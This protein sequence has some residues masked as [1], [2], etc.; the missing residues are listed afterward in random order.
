MTDKNLMATTEV[1]LHTRPN[2]ENEL[3]Q[4]IFLNTAKAALH[5]RPNIDI[6]CNLLNIA[7]DALRIMPSIER[8]AIQLNNYVNIRARLATKLASQA[9]RYREYLFYYLLGLM[10]VETL[11]LFGIVFVTAPPHQLIEMHQTTLQVIVGAT[12]IQISAMVIVIVKSVFPEDMKHLV[13]VAR[14]Y[15]LIKQIK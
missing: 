12:I 11:F 6:G 5:A 2:I 10:T 3:N 8:D 13:D 14:E 1:A 4:L 15:S 7:F 9:L